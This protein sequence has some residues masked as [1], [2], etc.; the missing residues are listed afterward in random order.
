MHN[1]HSTKIQL[2]FHNLVLFLKSIFFPYVVSSIE[3]R[4]PRKS[5]IVLIIHFI[6][7]YIPYTFYN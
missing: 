3:I 6:K 5:I 2:N 1:A 7:I 4:M